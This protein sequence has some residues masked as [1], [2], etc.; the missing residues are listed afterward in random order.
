M[1]LA[2]YIT[3]GHLERHIRRLKKRYEKKSQH[4]FDLLHTYLPEA[5]CILEEA[6][7]QYVL[8]FPYEL[9][10]AEIL[11]EGE[12]KGIAF[13]I[14]SCQELVISFAAIAEKDMDEGIYRLRQLLHENAI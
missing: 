10:Y 14:N 1:A 13:N 6:S 8:R 3:D 4:M 5:S 9:N 7:L 11:V 2:R 12:K